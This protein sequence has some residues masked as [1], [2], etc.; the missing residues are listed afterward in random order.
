MWRGAH[1]SRRVYHENTPLCRESCSQK[2]NSEL[3][4]IL[5]CPD[6]RTEL[7]KADDELLANVNSAIRDGRVA[8]RSG[9][10]RAEPID[11][12]LVRAAHDVMY[13]IVDGIPLLLREEAISLD[14]L[15]SGRSV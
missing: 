8:C 10:R 6:D 15:S 2:M 12:G 4:E 3:L 11:G 13:P 9:E 14:Q 7:T 1:P 5:R